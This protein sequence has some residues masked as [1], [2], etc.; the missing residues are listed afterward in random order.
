MLCQI[1]S[2]RDVFSTNRD[3]EF[4]NVMIE[5]NADCKIVGISDVQMNTYIKSKLRFKD[6]RHVLEI[7]FNLISIGTLYDM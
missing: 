1:T 4:G 7:R 3:C 5:N 6:I 2:R